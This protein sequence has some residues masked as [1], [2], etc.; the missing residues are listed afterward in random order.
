MGKLFNFLK[1]GFRLVSPKM[2]TEWEEPFIDEPCV[3]V[4]SH[5]G[6]MGPIYMSI[7]FP[8]CDQLAIWCNEQVMNRSEC[9]EYVRHDF[10]WKPESKLAPLWSATI[11]HVA[12][13]VLPPVLTSAP[14]IPVYH[15]ARVMTTI[16][17]S[18][19]ALRDGKHVVIFPEKPSGYGEYDEHINTGWLNLCVLYHR[20]TGKALR[21]WPVF[22]DRETH[23]FRVARHVQYDPERPLQEQEEHLAVILGCGLRGE[24]TPPADRVD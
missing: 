20:M 12:A 4:C 9:A 21:L 2:R 15:D 19:K 6:A 11:P 10:W 14:T 22:I 1:W 8:M 7:S 13:A 23:T 18:I 16:R 24:K 17:Q 3:F 5:V